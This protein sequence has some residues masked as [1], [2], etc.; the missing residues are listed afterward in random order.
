[1][2][3]KHNLSP[4]N[5][6]ET[7][8]EVESIISNEELE[9]ELELEEIENRQAPTESPDRTFA[10]QAV[11]RA[12]KAEAE[13]KALREKYE[14][15]TEATQ[16]TTNPLTTQDI[17]VRILK[18][19]GTPADEIEMLKKLAALKSVETGKEVSI[20]DMESDDY[21]ITYKD[22][23]DAT[24]KAEKAR[25]GASKSGGSAKAEKSFNTQGLSPADHKELWRQSQG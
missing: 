19:K 20:I 13:A 23:K 24:A 15:K 21:F 22:K 4:T 9:L 2:I 25:L 7:N 17:E 12:K 1:M 3:V 5:M 8:Q 14:G 10:R 11:A 16:N 6:P 18:V